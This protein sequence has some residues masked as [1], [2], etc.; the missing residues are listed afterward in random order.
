MVY[1]AI[2]LMS[3]SSLDGLDIVFTELEDSGG[4]WKYEIK[5]ANCY[6]YDE[7]WVQKLQNAPL[8]SAR[9][10]MLLHAAYGRYTAGLV[11]MFIE[12]HNLYHRVQLIASH[13]HTVFHDPSHGISTQLGDGATIA[14]LT[15]INVV[16]DLRNI[17][18]ALGG[19]GA[20][21]V[22][23][24]EKLL[25]EGYD[26]FLN[27]GGIA[28]LSYHNKDAVTAFDVCPANRILNTLA[29]KEGKAYDEDGKIAASGKIYTPLLTMLNRQDYYSK[30]YPKSLANEF[31]TQTILP[32]VESF[33][34]P[35]A[36]ALR[37]YTEHIAQQ[38]A[39]AVNAVKKAGTEAKL[40]VTGGGAF[41]SFLVKRLQENLQ[42]CNTLATVAD[43]ST[44]K[45][46]EALVMALYG[47][48]RWREENTVLS[49]VTGAMRNSIGGAV[50][51]GQEA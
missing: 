2:G 29:Q 34:L 38:V 1:R 35:T 47:I 10:Y 4:K 49:S 12:E 30:P 44:V 39:Y 20:P 51:I 18:V 25:F 32:L 17:D 48:L 7:E 6:T 33:D 43:E 31:G 41:N 5:A 22:P 14:A 26:F 9:D 40:L 15:G 23:I 3:G 16:S 8:L 24:G 37:T 13:G 42:S 21:I 36:D 27:I 11:N 50:W 19:Q 28:N 45:Y 46:K